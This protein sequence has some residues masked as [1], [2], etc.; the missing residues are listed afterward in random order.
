MRRLSASRANSV[1]RFQLPK[2]LHRP[3]GRHGGGSAAKLRGAAELAAPPAS[4]RRSA[5]RRPRRKC[6]GAGDRPPS[7][8][9]AEVPDDPARAA[10]RALP[11]ADLDSMA[12]SRRRRT[13]R[14]C[15][16]TS[17]WAMSARG[18]RAGWSTD[19]LQVCAR[20]AG[21]AAAGA[22][23]GG[24]LAAGRRR[25]G[26]GGGQRRGRWRGCRTS[27]TRRRP[28]AAK[29]TEGLPVLQQTRRRP[30]RCRSRRRR[31][32]HYPHKLGPARRESAGVG[33]DVGAAASARA[34]C[35]GTR[36]PRGACSPSCAP[37]CCEEI[38]AL[39][40]DFVRLFPFD[41]LT[42][43]K[44]DELKIAL[45]GVHGA[46]RR[47]ALLLYW[48]HIAPK[49][50]DAAE[51]GGDEP[52]MASDD[53][54]GALFCA[55]HEHWA[56]LRARGDEAARARA[57]GAA[58]AAALAR[59]CVEALFRAFPKWWTTVDAR[60]TLQT[61]D[62][63]IETMLDPDKYHSHIS[64]LESSTEAIRIAARDELGVKYRAREA[65]FY[66]TSTMVRAALP[67][68]ARQRAPPRRRRRPPARRRSRRTARRRRSSY[69]CCCS[70]PR[71]MPPPTTTPRRRRRRRPPPP[72]SHRA[73]PRAPGS[74][75][76]S[77]RSRAN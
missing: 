24:G 19:E 4:S 26:A 18:S 23:G 9:P 60:D 3:A 38:V 15:G 12:L 72:H 8:W 63:A 73:A 43:L 30:E 27:I 51:A 22:R 40:A 67:R 58:A 57:D 74:Y 36:R 28:T 54:L 16:S 70:A 59:V 65:R 71:M 6:V 47:P 29:L 13:S 20:A 55:T 37:S 7:R 50:K 2:V 53:Q 32:P 48:V 75:E 61:I 25:G 14:S 34:T 64:S 21:G 42:R 45:S 10:Q 17:G 11:A 5:S 66:S 33:R 1:C 31:R 68:A 39:Q 76:D 35:S 41:K 56:Q 69:R 46:L 52:D 44:A 49:A 62:A 77:W